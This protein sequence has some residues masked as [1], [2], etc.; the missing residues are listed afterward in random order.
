MSSTTKVRTSELMGKKKDELLKQLDE[1]KR[2]LVS[3]RV[4]KVAGGNSSKLMR[5]CVLF[6]SPASSLE[7]LMNAFAVARPARASQR[8]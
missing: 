3:L 1:L 4:Q 7:M 2:E 5:M 6:P 8:S